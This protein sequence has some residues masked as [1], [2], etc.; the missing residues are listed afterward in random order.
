[1]K[2]FHSLA[3]R[4][5]GVLLTLSAVLSAQS[6]S[7]RVVDPNGLPIQGITVDPGRGSTAASTDLNGLFT[8]TGLQNRSYDVEYRPN[9]GA[10]WVGRLIITGV[11]GATNVGDVVLQPGFLV[12]GTARTEA[13]VGIVGCNVNVY[14]QSG[15]KLFTPHDGSIAGGAFTVTVPAGTWDIRIN[16]PVAS[17]LVPR[18]FADTALTANLNLGNVTL[19]TAYQVAGTVVDSVSSVPVGSTRIRAYHAITREPIVLL[20]DT[21]ST[22]GAFTLLLPYGIL[23]LEFEPPVGNSHIGKQVFG[24]IVLGTMSLGQV[25][26]QNGVMLS[27]TVTGPAGG[28]A[29]ADVDVFAADGSKVYTAHDQTAFNGAFSVPVPSGGTY[30]VRV[31]PPASAGLVG[32]F[33]APVVV[34]A[35]TNVG[36]IALAAGIAVSGTITGPQGPEA[37]ANLNFFDGNGVEIVTVGDHTDAAGH[38][39]T[40]VPAGTWRIDVETAEGS[41]GKSSSTTGV[42]IAAATTWNRTVAQKSITAAVTSYGIP[43]LLQGGLLPVNP[44]LFGLEA[45]PVPTLLDLLVVL[46]NGQELPVFPTLALDVIPFPLQLNGIW[47]PMPV[48]PATATG[49]LLKFVMRCRDPL[50]NAVQDAASTE[51]VVL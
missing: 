16:P 22:F 50:T 19:P 27:G 11:S 33:G 18:E 29:G 12:S 34:N 21:A 5:F 45:N 23:D 28:V 31:E 14:D 42:A 13:G 37:N 25:R 17:L 26:L 4:A 6:L 40:F 32:S 43:T 38:F 47:L 30:R 20:A 8:V 1:M 2:L 35:A 39:A 9:P 44:F 48:V 3:A 24:A 7:G 51:F 15:A 41:H 49:K 36:T 10:T 46:P